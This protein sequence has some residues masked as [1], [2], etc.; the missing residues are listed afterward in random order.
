MTL[1]SR[2]HRPIRSFVRRE[3]RITTAQ[4]RALKQFWPR[5][6]LDSRDVVDPVAIY[7][8]R[9]PWVVEIGFGTGD[10]LLA[11]ARAHPECD[12]L[13][14]EVHRPGIGRLLRELDAAALSNVRVI[15]GDAID[16]LARSIA[17]DALDAVHVFFPDPWPKKRHHKRRLVVPDFVSIIVRKLKPG[18]AVHVATDWQDYAQQMLA[19]FEAAPGL[20]NTAGP[21]QYAPRPDGRLETR[22]ERRGRGLG[23][24]VFDLT[25]RRPG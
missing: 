13:G 25:F 8:R 2:L 4:R 14:I 6:G 1:S 18:G 21:G 11:A 24:Q 7:G 16:V 22:F 10:A 9:A 15:E 19:T 12:Y 17:D 20:V 3:G 5:F 23:H